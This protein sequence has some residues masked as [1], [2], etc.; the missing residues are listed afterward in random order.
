MKCLQKHFF[1]Y[2]HS[3]VCGRWNIV[4]VKS[5]GMYSLGAVS[6]VCQKHI[7]KSFIHRILK[8]IKIHAV[9]TAILL[10]FEIRV[11]LN[12]GY[13]RHSDITGDIFV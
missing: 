2:T 11:P 7:A 3:T 8:K 10:F 13:F 1:L 5:L 6:L 12:V 4:I 9:G